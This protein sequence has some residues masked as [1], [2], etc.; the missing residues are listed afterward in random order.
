MEDAGVT[1]HGEEPPGRALLT[2]TTTPT[3]VVTSRPSCNSLQRLQE[4][5]AHPHPSAD[6]R[7]QTSRWLLLGAGEV[8]GLG[9]PNAE[10]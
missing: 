10:A 9:R 6:E 8:P 5:I 4:G 7:Y 2:A 1:T 3:M